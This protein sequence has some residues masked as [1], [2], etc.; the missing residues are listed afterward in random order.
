MATPKQKQL[1][2]RIPADLHR[3]L[4]LYAVESERS[5]A[6]LVTTAV[7]Q[8]LERRTTARGA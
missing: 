8:L 4:K 2:V 1:L 5:M 7:R 6:S 3:E